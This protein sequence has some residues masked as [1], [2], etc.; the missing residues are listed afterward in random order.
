MFT[1]NFQQFKFAQTGLAASI[2]GNS[3]RESVP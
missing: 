2:E 3:V 1:L